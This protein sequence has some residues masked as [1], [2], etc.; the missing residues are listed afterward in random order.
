[1]NQ[2]QAT[3]ALSEP[4]P[5]MEFIKPPFNFTGCKTTLL[6]QLLPL[7]NYQHETFVD[8]FTGGG[9]VWC[10]VAPYFRKVL[11]NDIIADLIGIQRELLER[12]D[13]I[14]ATKALCVSKQDKEGY[15]RR[16]DDYNANPSPAGLFMLMQSCNNNMLRLNAHFRF[17]QTFGRRSWNPQTDIKVARY[18]E[19]IRKFRDRVTLTSGDF[20]QAQIP[21][22]SMVYI[23]PPYSATEAGYNAIWKKSLDDRRLFEHV[24]LLDQQGHSV[25]VSGVSLHNG[26]ECLLL[27]LLMEA[28]WTVTKLQHDYNGVSKVGIKQTQEVLLTNYF[29][30]NATPLAI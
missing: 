7:F 25:A 10:N 4:A 9:S 2:N 16:R 29:P 28:G 8:L 19:H 20:Q 1:M 26:K 13:I 15:H 18:T 21:A 22:N 24:E 11:A 30:G 12:D 14:A 3:L 6:P 23:D 27:N 17:N 5:T